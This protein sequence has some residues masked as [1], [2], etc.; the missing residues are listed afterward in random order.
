[1][2]WAIYAEVADLRCFLNIDLRKLAQGAFLEQDAFGNVN[3]RTR[4]LV[5]IMF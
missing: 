4:S 3:F 1:M 5:R 2:T